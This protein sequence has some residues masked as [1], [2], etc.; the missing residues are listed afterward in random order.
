MPVSNEEFKIARE[1]ADSKDAVK[2]LQKEI[3]HKEDINQKVDY[4]Y[5]ILKRI[6]SI[7]FH[8]KLL[9]MKLNENR[10][11]DRKVEIAR[12]PS[13]KPKVKPIESDDEFVPQK[14]LP[15]AKVRPNE[16][17]ESIPHFPT[18]APKY[19][20]QRFDPPINSAQEYLS[21]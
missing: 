18:E 12:P 16:K 2:V 3:E 7:F 13:S 20:P 5:F 14:R 8:F 6:V 4:V 1:I 21:V 17:N 15:S 10:E 9:E 19:E 11:T